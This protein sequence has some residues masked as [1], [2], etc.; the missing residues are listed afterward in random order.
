M[1]TLVAR[2]RFMIA[3]AVVAGTL[4][5]FTLQAGFTGWRA[6]AGSRWF[7]GSARVATLTVGNSPFV[8]GRTPMPT[9]AAPAATPELRKAATDL[10]VRAFRC[11]ALELD[12]LYIVR[13][14]S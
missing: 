10:V 1:L 4:A 6:L 5:L 8:V 12:R 3:L 11:R 7:G 14:L 9:T 2:V 13:P